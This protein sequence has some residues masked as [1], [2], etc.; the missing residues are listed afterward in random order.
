MSNLV[1]QGQQTIG[2][3][4]R[5]E[6]FRL[7]RGDELIVPSLPNPKKIEDVVVGPM[8]V[9]ARAGDGSVLEIATDERVFV[10][11]RTFS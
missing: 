1:H 4:E 10:I 6:S 9:H 8:V 5:V 11:R 2:R 3:I 7:C